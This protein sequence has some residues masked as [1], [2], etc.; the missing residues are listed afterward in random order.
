MLSY[1]HYCSGSFRERSCLCLQRSVLVLGV[2][3]GFSGKLFECRNA[4]EFCSETGGKAVTKWEHC[5][6]SVEE[7]ESAEAVGH[8]SLVSLVS[9]GG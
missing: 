5:K 1:F 7:L 2:C 3:L 6:A 8:E 9:S 4:R